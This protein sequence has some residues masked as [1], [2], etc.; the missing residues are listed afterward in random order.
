VRDQR[1]TRPALRT[2]ASL[3]AGLLTAILINAIAAIVLRWPD[4]L[5]S[6]AWEWGL[7]ARLFV[8]TAAGAY[9][10]AR[11]ALRARVV[12]AAIAAIP[13]L[14]V[15]Y[16][17]WRTEDPVWLVVVIAIAGALGVMS[18]AALAGRAHTLTP[19]G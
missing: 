13:A 8:A 4:T 19:S 1:A 2:L 16:D 6:L 3:A 18:G 10:A 17:W 14:V 15:S 9:V 12:H 7:A 5:W 11:I